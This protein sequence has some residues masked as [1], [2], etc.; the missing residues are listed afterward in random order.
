MSGELILILAPLG[1]DGALAEQ[2]LRAGGFSARA[3]GSIDELCAELGNDVGAAVLTEEALSPGAILRLEEVLSRQPA[4][5]DLPLI[6]FGGR[7]LTVG[8]AGNLTLLDR[9]VRMRT[10]LS[11]VRTAL[12][13]RRKQYQVRDLL[14]A[15]EQSVRDRDQFLA[16]LG[17]ELRNPLAALVT[18]TEIINRQAGQGFVRERNVISR[19]LRHLARL[20]DDLLDVS[21]ITR[22]Q[23][24]MRWEDVDLVEL[25][26]RVVQ[27]FEAA[28]QA[29]SVHLELVPGERT[30][31]VHA[32]VIRLEQVVTNLLSNAIKYTNAGGRVTV[33]LSRG[34]ADAELRV[35][36]TG[37]GISPEMLPRV[38]D[39]FAQAPG[40][41]DRAQGGMGI[42]LT[43]VQRLVALHGGTVDAISPGLGKGSEFVVHIPLLSKPVA[44][45]GRETSAEN[46]ASAPRLRLVI[47]ED[48][49][50]SRELLQS[51][52]EEMGHS[53]IACADGNSAI[54]RALSQAPDAMLVDLGLPGRDGFEVAR[55]IRGALGAAVRLVALT[56]YGQSADRE[57][58]LQAG[59]DAFLVKPASL[60][61]VQRAL[62]P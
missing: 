15:L 23:I 37:L 21:R 27:G 52:L 34:A 47:A 18:A 51:A 24:S 6:V 33:T 38:F 26:S 30:I 7:D 1:R 46:G 29:Q 25:V 5:S 48:N 3:C 9:P 59:F 49:A 36:D 54:Q 39:L 11:A 50:D 19:Q 61:A 8:E 16:M 2:A 40:T 20:V 14:A 60:D 44:L 53:V 13:A 42:G 55:E 35:R 28:A 4:W 10:L 56:G 17:H 12:R 58:A 45:P 43:L 62:V 31:L 41:L 32:D 57:R 22:G